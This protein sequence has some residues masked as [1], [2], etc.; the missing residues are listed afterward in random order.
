VPD[1]T[2]GQ[3]PEQMQVTREYVEQLRKEASA[4]RKKATDLEARLKAEDDKKLSDQERIAREL[5]EARAETERLRQERQADRKRHAVERLAVEMAF[6]D[7]EDAY[8]AVANQVELDDNDLPTNVKRL[9]EGLAKA[10]PYLIKAT[11]G[12]AGVPATPRAAGAPTSDERIGGYQ[13]RLANSGA[14][15]PL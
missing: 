9:L 10:K 13:Q 5:A 7:P 8:A 4:N 12:T 6:H 15:S 1:E 3:M 11:N 2:P 14:Y